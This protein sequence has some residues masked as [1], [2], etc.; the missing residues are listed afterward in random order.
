MGIIPRDGRG[1]GD[2]E[3]FVQLKTLFNGK[4][5]YINHDSFERGKFVLHRIVSL[6]RFFRR[7]DSDTEKR[8]PLDA[9]LALIHTM[10]RLCGYLSWSLPRLPCTFWLCNALDKAGY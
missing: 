2:A 5:C 6:E 1:Y 3:A 4:L 7:S 10:R 8:Q 9:C